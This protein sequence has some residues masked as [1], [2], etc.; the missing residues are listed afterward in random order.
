M[1]AAQVIADTNV[2]SYAFRGTPLG[3]A[4]L[5][6]IGERRIGVTGMCLAELRAGALIGRWGERKVTE[7]LRFI[8]RFTHVLELEGVAEVCGA[9]RGIREQIGRPIDLPDAWAAA[10]ALWLDV[11]LVTHDRDL[12]GI[13]GLRVLTLHDS[14][15]IGEN[16]ADAG[17]SAG[18]WLRERPRALS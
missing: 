15:R 3:R 1:N 4:Y 7:L 5:Q 14:W 6:L 2:V 17:T 9:L 12:E 13:P 8:E 16:A 10:C 18:I 11:P